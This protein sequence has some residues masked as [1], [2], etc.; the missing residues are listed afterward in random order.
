MV[1]SS[2]LFILYFLPIFLIIYYLSPS[3]WRNY[4]ILFFSIIFY[5]WGAPKFVFLL[6]GSSVANFY[7]VKELSKQS[8][9]SKKKWYLAL[10]IFLN[11]SIL[12]YF[13]YANFFLEN[14]NVFLSMFN[15]NNLTWTKI[16]LPIGI[17]FFTFQ[18][19]TYSVDV[20]RKIRSPLNRVTDY[21]MYIMLFPQM[22][23]GPIVRFNTI[24]EEINDRKKNETLDNILYGFILFSIGLGKKVLLANPMGKYADI[25]FSSDIANMSTVNAWLGVIAYG[26]QIY[27]DFSGYSDMAIGIGRM[28]GFTFPENFNAPYISKSITEF[29]RRWH[30]TLGEWMKDYLYIP[31]G[32]NRVNSKS[33]VFFNL[34]FVFLV[35]GFWHGASWN[36]VLWGIYHGSFL[37]F[38]RIFLI[39]LTRKF[40][41]HVNII[42]TYILVLIGWVIFR[43]ESVEEI[44]TYFKQMFIYKAA[45]GN[46]SI[47]QEYIVIALLS[48][49]FAFLPAT[50]LGLRLMNLVYAKKQNLNSLL[51]LSIVSLII[52]ALSIGAIS[53]SKFNPFIYFRF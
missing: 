1:F 6:I 8:N 42:L 31:L 16:V 41:K 30:I 40:N 19:I 35:S 21:I 3:T 28:I 47:S 23:A 29:W 52:L 9:L 24:A 39:K 51:F 44:H 37:I 53:T 50:K 14:V 5:A 43:C 38:D 32:G 20:F 46:L 15:F 13:K 33:R 7:V 11:L 36:F 22:I 10:S 18:S 49:V 17:S 12:I 48:S 34:W 26:F 25:A 45:P 27:Y 4:I 2:N